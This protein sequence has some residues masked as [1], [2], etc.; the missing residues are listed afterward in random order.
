MDSA[1]YHQEICDVITQLTAAVQNVGMYPHDHPQIVSY[2]QEAHDCLGALLKTKRE[3][4]IMRIGEYLMVDNRPLIIAGTYETAFVRILKKYS[5]ERVTF[6]R[7]LPLVQLEKLIH[8]L[9]SSVVSLIRSTSHIRVGKLKLK[10]GEEESVMEDSELE[11]SG[12]DGAATLDL[13]SHSPEQGIQGI[14]QD[15]MNNNNIDLAMVD[16]IVI[17]FM[18]NL[19]KEANPLKLLAEIKANDEYTYAHASNVGILTMFLAEYLGFKG[20]NLNE[21]GVAA[22]L[23]DVGKTTIPDNILSKPDMLT[24]DERAVME[25]HPVRG[26][27][28]LM[29]IKGVKN[30]A[31]L[32]AMEHH[33]KFDGSG[34][35]RKKRG[36]ETNIV[37]QMVAVS[38]VFDALRTT[39]PYRESMPQDQIVQI[40][41]KESGTTF[42]PYLSERFL[43]LIEKCN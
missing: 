27:M 13:S 41:T 14:Y 23:H 10:D 8:N 42:N 17:N 43:N 2:I 32:A 7:G 9:A 30:L 5:I 21:I 19:R 15:A 20:S 25:T 37:S 33:M 22:I 12:E 6:L 40:I 3:I 34:Y 38:D 18:E 39:R 11:L 35:P 29:E 16:K 36:W 31:V 1:E 28:A 26:G 24:Y 4:T